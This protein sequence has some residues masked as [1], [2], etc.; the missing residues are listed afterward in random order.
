MYLSNLISS[1]KNSTI[2]FRIRVNLALN[3]DQE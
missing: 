3:S 1:K 2:N